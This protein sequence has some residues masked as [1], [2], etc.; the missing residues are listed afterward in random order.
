MKK[1]EFE[2][3][4]MMFFDAQEHPEKYTDEQLRELLGNEEMQSFFHHMAMMKRAM[5]KGEEQPQVDVDE[6]W[7]K[8]ATTHHTSRRSWTRAAAVTSGIVLLSGVAL[9][10]TLQLGLFRSRS[11]NTKPNEAPKTEQAPM[12]DTIR[13][14]T[15]MPKDTT[16]MSPVTFEDAMLNDVLSSMAAFYQVKVTFANETSRQIRLYFKWDK[17]LPLQQQ[18]DLLNGFERIHITFSNN[19]INVE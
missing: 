16:D 8:F 10:A 12:A 1:M 18:I 15:E 5:V 19:T 7:R 11:E 9:A 4:K 2:E 3:K 17:H 14:T 6:E 13:K